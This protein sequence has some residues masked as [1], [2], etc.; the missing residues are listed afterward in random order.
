MESDPAVRLAKKFDLTNVDPADRQYVY[1]ILIAVLNFNKDV[2][3][4]LTH[5]V[6]KTPD[7]YS[8]TLRGWN[9]SIDDRIWYKK[10]LSKHRSGALERILSTQTIPEDGT[11]KP[12]KVF[13][14][15]RS[16]HAEKAQIRKK[17]RARE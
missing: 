6:F 11:G 2:M 9:T 7:H 8:L 14:I 5:D 3:P 1:E 10:F 15:S 17:K 13:E 12:C 16:Y 4:D